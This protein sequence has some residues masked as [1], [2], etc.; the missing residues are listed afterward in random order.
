MRTWLCRV[1]GDVLVEIHTGE[2]ETYLLILFRGEGGSLALGLSYDRMIAPM[3][4][5]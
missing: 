4:V 1:G 3:T 2:H 5:K